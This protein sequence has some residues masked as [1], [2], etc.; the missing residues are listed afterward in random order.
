MK[1]SDVIENPT[2]HVATPTDLLKLQELSVRE[3]RQALDNWEE[4]A[5]RLAVA[6]DEGMT[7]G[8][9]S[10]LAEVAEAKN[11]LGVSGERR[12]WSPTKTC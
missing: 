12:R 6:T 11:T 2:A 7:G 10:R 3:K 9:P 1:K 8:E 5:R 4:D